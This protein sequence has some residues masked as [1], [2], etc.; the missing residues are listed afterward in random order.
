MI[1]LGTWE[2]EG[3][4]A[5][6]RA[7]RRPSR[8]RCPRLAAHRLPVRHPLPRRAA[9]LRR[10]RSRRGC[11]C[12]ATRAAPAP[13]RGCVEAIGE[14][15]L[16][17]DIPALMWG[18]DVGVEPTP[19]AEAQRLAAEA[20]GARRTWFL[21]NGASQGN[22]VALLTLAHARRQRRAPAQ[23]ALEHHRRAGAVRAAPDV[24]GARA[25]PRP[26]HRPLP[27]ARGARPRARARRRARSAR[28]SCRRPTSARWPTWRRWRRWR[29]AHGVPLI[30]DEAWG[31]HLAFSDELPD[32][33]AGARAPTWSSRARTRSSAAS[34]SRRWSTSGTAT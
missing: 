1:G 28:R 16:A 32:A 5:G 15:A 17:L 24:R 20:W 10:A 34:P 7:P 2:I 33:R 31:A 21:V 3:V 22:H 6:R 25:R 30:V 27:D 11:T 12:P 14:R 18:I 13:T 8:R 9:R 19:F 29:T 23:R 4:D 26:A